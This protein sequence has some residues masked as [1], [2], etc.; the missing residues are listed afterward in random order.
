LLLLLFSAHAA[1]A[2]NTESLAPAPVPQK[3]APS[4][5]VHAPGATKYMPSKWDL[6]VDPGEKIPPLYPR[7][8]MVYWLHEEIDPIAWVPGLLGTGWEQLVDGNPNY[9]SDSAAF[10]ERLGATVIRD[11]SM[12]FFS[13]SL[14]PTLTHE[15]PRYYRKAHG[16]IRAR[17]IYAVERVLIAQHDDGSRGFNY[18]D[19]VGH[20]AASALTPTYYPG[21]SSS[22][23][24][25]LTTWA[26]SLVGD[27][28]GKAFLEFWPDAHRLIE[29]RRHR[30]KSE[31]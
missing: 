9:G 21:P 7:D 25:V 24:V 15:D 28:G 16:S 19:T 2:Q 31:P 18:S 10:G 11:T 5:P 27:A 20:L 30:H 4:Q 6:G 23:R 22:A 26:L 29:A 17:S 1:L 14:A 13:N 12:R 3:K 8:K